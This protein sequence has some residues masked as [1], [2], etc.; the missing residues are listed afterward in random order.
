MPK[1]LADTT[2]LVAHLRGNRKAYTFLLHAAPSVSHVTI[3]ELIQGTKSKRQLQDAQQSYRDLTTIPIDQ[4]VSIQAIRLMR[5]LFLSHGLQF[6][7]AV[8][9]A[10]ALKEDMILVTANIKHFSFIKGLKVVDWEKL[11]VKTQE[12]GF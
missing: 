9:A 10:T 7:D 4:S 5:K 6:L 1:Y 12:G 2:V 3:A 11:K 8:V